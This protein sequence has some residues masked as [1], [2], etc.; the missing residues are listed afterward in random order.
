MP[1]IPRNPFPERMRRGTAASYN[2]Q[3]RVHDVM[4]SDPKNPIS[5]CSGFTAMQLIVS[6]GV[7]LILSAVSAKPLSALIYRMRLQNAAEGIKHMIQN[8]R[9]RSVA[10]PDRRCGV[11]FDFYPTTSPKSDNVFAFLEGNPPDNIYTAA[12]D[13]LY[14]APFVIPRKQGFSVSVPLGYPTVLT[15]RGD[16]SALSSA[17]VLLTYKGMQFTVDVLASTGRVKVI[18]Q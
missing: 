8:A 11:V 13:Q 18:K 3:D 5:G 7:M 9:V 14:L 1:E 12:R 15:F 6:A 17:K 4:A 2:G 10:N 16:G